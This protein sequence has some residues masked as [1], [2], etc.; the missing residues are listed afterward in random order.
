MAYTRS[1]DDERFGSLWRFLFKLLETLPLSFSS[2]LSNWARRSSFFYEAVSCR[3]CYVSI[4]SFLLI[5]VDVPRTISYPLSYPNDLPELL[6]ML[7][8]VISFSSGI[9]L[10][11]NDSLVANFTFW[12]F[13]SSPSSLRN[14]DLKSF[15]TL[16][17]RHLESWG[18]LA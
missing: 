3:A 15:G 7:L 6:I 5:R 1:E 11:F 14:C 17:V 16:K 4:Y 12:F 2:N 13:S 18:L 8:S 9:R 10:I